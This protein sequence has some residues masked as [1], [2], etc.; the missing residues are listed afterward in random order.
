MCLKDGEPWE[1]GFCRGLVS[2]R[3]FVPIM[4]AGA[5]RKTSELKEDSW[6][7]NV[8][9][10]YRMA[11]ELHELGLVEYVFPLMVGEPV[12]GKHFFQAKVQLPTRVTTYRSSCIFLL[13]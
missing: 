7:D 5:L 1:D 11:L 4:S 2:S 13:R 9:L 8:L 12:E 3:T 6:C 10:E